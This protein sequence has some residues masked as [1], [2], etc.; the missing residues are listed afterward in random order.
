[1]PAPDWKIKDLDG[2]EQSLDQCRGG[3]VVMD[4]WFRQCSF[5]MRD[6]P[7]IEKVAA[8]FRQ[9]NA[10]IS[11]FGV[12]I[13]KEPADARFVADKIKLTYPVLHSQELSEQLGV[14]SYPT[15]LVISPEGA[16]QRIFDGYN[17]IRREDLT[18]RIRELMRK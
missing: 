14:S 7:Q 3:V 5:C 18:A 4:F 9:E 13:D 17:L 12:S 10:L 11:F 1:L 15:V 2:K 6:I 16:I 8:T